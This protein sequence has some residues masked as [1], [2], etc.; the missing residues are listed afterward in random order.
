MFPP[1]AD[2][3]R[4][5]LASLAHLVI[6]ARSFLASIPL[7]VNFLLI[8]TVHLLYNPFMKVA[9]YMAENGLKDD[10]LAAL[11]G[12]N[13]ATINRIRRGVGRPSFGLIKKLIE[14]TDG[15]VTAN[16]F[17]HNDEDAA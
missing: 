9:D 4:V 6:V 8:R 14:V 17:F 5:Q 15:A 7:G 16:D 2:K 3:G 12:R 13:R 11:V 1:I 10:D